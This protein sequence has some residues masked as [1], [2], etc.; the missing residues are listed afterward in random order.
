VNAYGT[1]GAGLGCP[2]G[3]T[4]SGSSCTLTDA[5]VVE[6][7]ADTK[8]GLKLLAHSIAVDPN[9]P[10]CA[11]PELNVVASGD[12]VNAGTASKQVRAHYN[13]DGTATITITADT[14]AGT[15]ATQTYT[16][17]APGS[18]PGGATGTGQG[19]TRTNGIASAIT[20]GTGTG[21]TGDPASTRECG[22]PGKPMCGVKVDESGT[23]DTKGAEAKGQAAVDQVNA[24]KDQAVASQ[25]SKDMTTFGVP[26]YSA[27]AD[28]AA[29]LQLPIGGS[30]TCTA[31]TITM[32]GQTISLD[33]VCTVT[34]AIKPILAWALSLI[35]AIYAWSAYSRRGAA[36]A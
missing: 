17:G 15:T 22:V 21:T 35:A 13:A 4:L 27:P 26:G 33:G 1:I 3:Y 23:S 25:T 11:A 5:T 30:D 24:L 34:Q 19:A 28:D 31:P 32:R 29:K 20:P 10:D 2:T 6:K 14:G 18:A 9:D 7:P 16:F 12:E 8:C 36:G